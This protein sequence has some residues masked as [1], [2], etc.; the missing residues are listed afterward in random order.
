MGYSPVSYLP[1]LICLSARKSCRRDV[2]GGCVCTVHQN[3]NNSKTY[4]STI[5]RK[6]NLHIAWDDVLFSL[7]PLNE[8]VCFTPVAQCS[9]KTRRVELGSTWGVKGNVYGMF[10]RHRHQ[11]ECTLEIRDISLGLRVGNCQL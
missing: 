2:F 6:L 7:F 10:S 4:I 3:S 1:E 8:Y 5:P 11:V 9:T